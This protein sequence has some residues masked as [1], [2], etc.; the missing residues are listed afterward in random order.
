MWILFPHRTS[1]HKTL[2]AWVSG[3][4][5][6]YSGQRSVV[7]MA[8]PP[9]KNPHVPTR[10]VGL[11]HAP[12][13]PR[14]KRWRLRVGLVAWLALVLVATAVF[15]KVRYLPATAVLPGLSVDGVI[16]PPG[17]DEAALA[18]HVEQRAKSLLERKVK[19]FLPSS[20]K[21]VLEASLEELGM[22]VDRKAT[23]ETAL[24]VG[25][26]GD[27]YTRALTTR[28]SRSGEID[29]PLA[30]S[31]DREAAFRVLSALKE[32]EDLQP[33]SARLDLEKHATIP[34]KEGVYIDADAA[35][36]AL[37]DLV[38]DRR[39]ENVKLPVATFAPRI[40]QKFLEGLDISTVVAEYETYFSRTGDQRER[41][42]NIDNA[43]LKLDGLVVSPGEMVSFNDVIGER[44]EANGFHKA[45]EIFKGEMVEG[46]GGGTCQVA[47]TFHAAVFFAGFDLLERLPHSRPSGYITMGLDSTVVYPGVDLKVRN[48]HPFPMV[49]HAK[50][51]GWKLRVELLGKER[52]VKVA[53]GRELLETIPYKR[54]IIEEAELSGKKVIVKQ[55]GIRGYKIRRSRTLTFANG[56]T[57]RESVTDTYPPTTEIYKVPV[58]FDVALLPP[59]PG[60]P[61][62]DTD[63]GGNPSAPPPAARAPAADSTSAATASAETPATAAPDIE[64]VE[65]PGAHAP[66]AQQRDPTKTVVIKR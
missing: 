23:V 13:P 39:A 35:M 59:L 11:R 37:D 2:A 16:V 4:D 25:K 1:V 41:G 60:G 34:E 52:P 7:S 49:V 55:H 22:R 38:K 17:A 43:A 30:A 47:S 21:P 44:S 40:S 28:A 66:T 6:R 62:E 61:N 26:F 9:P 18:A 15:V 32:A 58:G 19:L 64:F 63:L 48:P 42:K 20:D 14:K 54:K 57:K 50:T 5:D 3:A 10:I 24:R 51:V 46:V 27:L 36:A 45:Y 12:P 29:V 65:A 53:F 56:T 31:V 33:I 8:F